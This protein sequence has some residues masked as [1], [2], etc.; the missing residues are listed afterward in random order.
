[1][2]FGLYYKDELIAEYV[3][4]S[5]IQVFLGNRVPASKIK[6]FKVVAVG[7]A[8]T[9]DLPDYLGRVAVIEK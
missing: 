1:M 7:D 5:E 6:F 4:M 8:E 3:D 2:R 9:E